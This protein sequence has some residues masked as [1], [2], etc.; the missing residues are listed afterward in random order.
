MQFATHAICNTC[1]TNQLNGSARR[2]GW[3]D[4]QDGSVLYA[5]S[6]G[7]FAYSKIYL[8]VCTSS[9]LTSPT[10]A[11]LKVVLIFEVVFILSLSLISK[12]QFNYRQALKLNKILVTTRFFQLNATKYLSCVKYDKYAFCK[13]HVCDKKIK[14]RQVSWNTN[15]CCIRDDL[16]LQPRIFSPLAHN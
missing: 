7:Q 6:L 3:T 9:K 14:V 11:F 13:C 5:W 2:I 10:K 16:W 12:L 15:N 1:K 8:S 4:Q